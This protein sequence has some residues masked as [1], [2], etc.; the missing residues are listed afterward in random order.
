MVGGEYLRTFRQFDLEDVKQHLL[1]VGD[2]SGDC[3]SCR[4]LGIDSYS[5]KSC[6]QCGTVFKYVTSRRLEAHPGE[7]F[8]FARRI[9]QKRPD[10]TVLDYTDYDKAIGRKKARD[11]FG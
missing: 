11:F 9:Q 3:A 7:R 1:I 5:A 2:L 4:A 10:L 6:S 8:Q